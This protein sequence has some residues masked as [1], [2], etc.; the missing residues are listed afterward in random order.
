VPPHC[1]EINVKFQIFVMGAALLF[2]TFAYAQGL[3]LPGGGGACV[4]GVDADACNVYDDGSN[5]GDVITD[6][7]DQAQTI[8]GI[9]Q[10]NI[11]PGEAGGFDWAQTLQGDLEQQVSSAGGMPLVT[12]AISAYS[13]YWPG[14]SNAGYLQEPPPPGSPEANM[15]TTLGTLQGALQAGADQQQSQQA[16]AARMEDLENKAGN[17]SGN[18]QVQEVANE[19]ALFNGQEEMKQRNATN[20]TLNALLVAESNRQN[21][22]AQDDLESMAVAGASVPWSFANNPNPP[23]PTLPTE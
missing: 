9:E 17:A 5:P 15:S 3:P 23:E 19:I 10:Q 20:G 1:E 21:Q 14:Y 7:D 13:N 16:E 12:G 18:L 2:A 8:A 11:Q 6:T 4:G 22:K